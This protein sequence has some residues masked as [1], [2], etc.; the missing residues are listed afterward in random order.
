MAE[1]ILSRRRRAHIIDLASS[2]WNRRATRSRAPPM[3]RRRCKRFSTRSRTG[4]ARP[5]AAGT[6]RLGS[7]PPRGAPSRD[8]PIIMLTAP[9]RRHRPESSG[10]ELGADDYLTK[11][12]NRANWSPA[13]ARSCAAPDA[14]TSPAPDSAVAIDNLTIHPERAH[15]AGSRAKRSIWRM[16]ES[17]C[18]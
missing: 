17:T 18:S 1:T 5:D 3:A 8:V 4:R 15:R 13:C 7:L 9:Q 12:F 6:R 11:P 10:L 14:R 2:T 16:K